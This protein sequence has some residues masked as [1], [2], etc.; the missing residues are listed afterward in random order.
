MR[1]RGNL[2]PTPLRPPRHPDFYVQVVQ[3]YFALSQQHLIL[4]ISQQNDK[5]PYPI[6]RLTQMELSIW[7][8]LESYLVLF[9]HQ[10]IIT[11]AV[12]PEPFRRGTFSN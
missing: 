4:I 2:N 8:Y 5:I 6:L 9:T 10:E 12:K 7:K 11:E 1:E 3:Y